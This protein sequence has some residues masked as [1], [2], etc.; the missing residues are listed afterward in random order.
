MEGN[1]LIN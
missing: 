1:H